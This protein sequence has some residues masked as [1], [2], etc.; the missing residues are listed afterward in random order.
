MVKRGC[1]SNTQMKNYVNLELI[2]NSSYKIICILEMFDI[3]AIYLFN[4]AYSCLLP[5]VTFLISL[6]SNIAFDCTQVNLV[7]FYATDH[8]WLFFL[9]GGGGAIT[10]NLIFKKEDVFRLYLRDSVR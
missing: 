3:L 10:S 6:F 7:C 9:F 2:Q 5:P 8:V 4:L 1:H